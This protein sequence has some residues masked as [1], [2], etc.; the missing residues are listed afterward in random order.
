[1]GS[2]FEE[3]IVTVTNE[4]A[5]AGSDYEDCGGGTTELNAIEVFNESGVWSSPDPNIEFA[6]PSDALTTA[7]N[8]Q[9]GVNIF[10]WTI[11]GGECGAA[12]TDSVFVDYQFAPIGVNDSNNIVPFA[13]SI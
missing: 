3:I 6:D 11:Y 12:S 9:P 5:F 2:S 10:V 4:S 8:L 1:C 7:M 13:G